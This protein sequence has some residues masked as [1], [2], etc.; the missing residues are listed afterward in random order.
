[1]GKLGYMT[2]ANSCV[3]LQQAFKKHSEL[4]R[5]NLTIIGVDAADR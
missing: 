1:M 2:M 5:K 3:D 4:E